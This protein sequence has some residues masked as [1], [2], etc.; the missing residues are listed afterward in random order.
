MPDDVHGRL[1]QVSDPPERG[2]AQSVGELDAIGRHLDHTGLEIEGPVVLECVEHLDDEERISC[3]RQ[4]AVAQAWP[5][6]CAGERR[7]E[8]RHR[9]RVERV[10]E[11][12]FG[13]GVFEDIPPS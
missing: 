8:G 10:E 3:G 1:G 5:R 13:S 7:H 4:E 12:V 9:F 2:L 6:R 11:M